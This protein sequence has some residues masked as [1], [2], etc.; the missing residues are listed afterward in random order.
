MLDDDDGPTGPYA[1]IE[2]A[3]VPLAYTP[4]FVLRLCVLPAAKG[5]V[6]DSEMPAM[7]VQ[8]ATNAYREV[9]TAFVCRPFSLSA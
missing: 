9:S 8:I 2:R 3:G 7:T 1:I 5:V 6:Y 4:A